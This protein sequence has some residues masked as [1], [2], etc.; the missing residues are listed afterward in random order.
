MGFTHTPAGSSLPGTP[1]V[2]STLQAFAC[3][4]VPS[5][6]AVIEKGGGGDRE[7][8][9][10]YYLFAQATK[11]EGISCPSKLGQRANVQQTAVHK[12]HLWVCFCV[13]ENR[14]VP[15][16]LREK[17]VFFLD[18]SELSRVPVFSTSYVVIFP[19]PALP[20]THCL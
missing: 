15:L 8:V 4:T 14:L 5:Q 7:Q 3:W 12:T 9:V 13:L 10:T 20:C 19:K 11:A 17:N 2:N 1:K 16:W 6:T 18:N